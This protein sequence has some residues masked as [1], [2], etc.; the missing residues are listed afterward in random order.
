MDD[1]IFNEM[2]DLVEKLTEVGMEFGTFD[3]VNL[4]VRIEEIAKQHGLSEEQAMIYERLILTGVM[5]M[6]GTEL[7]RGFCWTL[8]NWVIHL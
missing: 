2:W 1:E 7:K 8:A 4:F 3:I 6:E 5:Q